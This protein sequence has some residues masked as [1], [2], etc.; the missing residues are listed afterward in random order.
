MN[1]LVGVIYLWIFFR[2]KTFLKMADE[3]VNLAGYMSRAFGLI[4][5]YFIFVIPSTFLFLSYPRVVGFVHWVSDSFIY[6][7]VSQIFISILILVSS[8]AYFRWKKYVYIL[9]FAAILVHFYF[10]F[11]PSADH[12]IMNDWSVISVIAVP[13]FINYAPFLLWAIS[14]L[15]CGFIFLF[16]AF[17]LKD[18][19]ARRRSILISLSMLI[20][21]LSYPLSRV[22]F[23]LDLP[24]LPPVLSFLAGITGLYIL[25]STSC[26]ISIYSLLQKKPD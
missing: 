18:R 25:T 24:T 19:F 6:L 7:G 11:V 13:S 2:F 26:I 20:F 10:H 15:V 14:F 16:L 4:A 21:S 3:S 9:T 1:F 5:A 12:A 17:R 23:Y 8:A 22:L